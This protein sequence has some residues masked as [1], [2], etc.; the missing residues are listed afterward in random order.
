[1]ECPGCRAQWRLVRNGFYSR[2]FMDE[3]RVVHHLDIQRVRCRECNAS[4]SQR[5]DFLVPYRRVGATPLEAAVRG[6]IEEP[7]T[8]LSAETDAVGDCSA[9][10]TAVATFL[11]Q[12][13]VVWMSVMQV[14][15]AA[16][17]GVPELLRQVMCPN[18]SR[19]RIAGK[20]ER[21]DWAASVLALVP[22]LFEVCAREGI[23]LLA[24]GRGCGL[25]RTHRT[26]CELF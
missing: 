21:L 22:E 26:E 13:P 16:G 24:S 12:L 7:N 25:L 18:S 20:A 3:E 17:F 8:Y 10:Y 5:Y 4:H 23:F 9:V 14:L 19:A 11:E 15:V 2:D 6:Y 1:M